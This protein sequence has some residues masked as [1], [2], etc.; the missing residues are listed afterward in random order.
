MRNWIKIAL[1]AATALI[2]TQLFVQKH[3]PPPPPGKAAPS[4]ALP[5][6]GGKTVSLEG[7]KGKVVAVNF[8]ATWCGPCQAE[9]P[10]LAA[11]WREHQGKCFELLGVAEESGREDVAQMAKQLPYPILVD[12]DAGALDTWGVESYP[13]TFLVDAQGHVRQVFRGALDRAE[14]TRAVAPLLPDSCPRT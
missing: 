12:K 8:W 13:T 10:D 14:L 3:D 1:V 7:L 9:L 2:V 5:D 4:L 11:A 6:L